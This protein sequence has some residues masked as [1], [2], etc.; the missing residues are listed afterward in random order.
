MPEHVEAPLGERHPIH[1]WEYADAAARLAATSFVP[2]DVGGWAKQLDN[3]T[4]WELTDD[5]P[6]VWQRRAGPPL[7]AVKTATYTVSA[8][9]DDALIYNSASAGT[10]NLPAGASRGPRPYYF[11][12]IGAGLLTLDPNGA[13]AIDGAATLDLAER[14][15]VAA[16]W[17]GSAWETF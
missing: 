16:F 11:K 7:L 10:F 13:E 4:Y 5:S 3:G 12:S 8:T 6:V 17:T 9:E 1:N 15:S 2:A 14:E